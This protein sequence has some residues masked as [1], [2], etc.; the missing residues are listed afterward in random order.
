[1]CSKTQINYNNK[2]HLV[3]AMLVAGWDKHGGGQVYGCP[4]GGTL[5]KDKWAIDGSGSTYVWAYCDSEF[6]Y[7]R[8]G[9]A[10]R[11]LARAR[12]GGRAVAQEAGTHG[13]SAGRL[14]YVYGQ[15]LWPGK[16]VVRCLARVDT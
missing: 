2:D 3:G 10:T 6:R 5:V 1:M 12:G 9:R 11:G 13:M 15:G 16:P 8:A 7:D 14:P 4:I